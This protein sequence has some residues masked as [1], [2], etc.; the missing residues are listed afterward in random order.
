MFKINLG[1]VAEYNPFH[2]GHL[3][4]IKE[5]KK[6]TNASNTIVV[7]S[8]NFMQRGTLAIFDKYERTAFALKNGVDLVIELPVPFATS[9]AEFFAR[10]SVNILNK[11]NI[12]DCISFGSESADIE[13]LNNVANFFYDEKKNGNIK[14]SNLLNGFL[15]SGNSYPLARQLAYNNYFGIDTNVLKSPNNILGVEYLKALLTL[16]SKIKPY[17]I[18]R[19]NSNYHSENIEGSIS[20]ATSI[21]NRIYN[22]DFNNQKTKNTLPINILNDISR[23]LELDDLPNY[24]NLSRILHHIFITSDKKDLLNILDIKEPSLNKMISSSNSNFLIEDILKST[25]SKNFN[26][27][28]LQRGLLHLILDIKKNEFEAS[29]Y[30]RVLGFKKEKSFLLKDLINNSDLPVVTNLKNAHKVLN[31]SGLNLL[32]KEIK[33]TDIYNLSKNKNYIKNYELYKPLIIL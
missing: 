9:S 13:K 24:N 2:L 1:I 33:S 19:V 4:H 16:N 20:S 26:K 27:T 28:S 7:M 11:T 6:I 31:S 21:R 32:N 17:T 3:L 25:L 12:I 22:N 30:I 8:G 10:E 15:R 14:Y 23:I 5:S 29:K 18:K